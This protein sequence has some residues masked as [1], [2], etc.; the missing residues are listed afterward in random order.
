MLIGDAAHTAHFSIGS[1]TKL[2]MEDAIALADALASRTRD[3]P[4]ALAA[5]EAERAARGRVPCSARRRSSLEWFE[6]TERYFGRLE[7]LQFAFRLLTRS[8]RITHANLKLRDPEFVARDRRAGSPRGRRTQSGVNV[9]VDPPPPPMFT[10]FRL[11]DMVLANRVVVSPMCQYSAED[12]MPN[13][14]HL[15]HLG[16]RAI[17]GAGLVMAEM[18]DVSREARITPGCAGHVQAR[19]RRRLAARR[20]LRAR[21]Q[22][23]PRSACS[24]RTPAARARRSMLWEGIDEPL[25]RRQLAAAR[26][27]RRSPTCRTARCRSEMD[28]ADMDT[29]RDDFVR[30]ARLAERGRLRP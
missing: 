12:G 16:S 26:R 2:A 24:S 10:P 29:V 6:E 25:R 1:G 5:Y 30:A 4:A 8:L 23:A 28:R 22:P 18:T 14:W 15:V 19:A 3:V 20:R 17:G 13:D 21:Q 27:R 9:P 7:P 11:R